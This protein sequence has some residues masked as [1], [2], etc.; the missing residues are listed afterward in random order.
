M[1]IFELLLAILLGATVLSLLAQR[2]HVPYPTL[3]AVGGAALAL[4]PGLPVIAIPP[5]LILALFVAPVLLNAAYESSL[6]D[7]KRNWRPIVSLVLVAVVLTAAVVALVSRAMIPGI[8]W[9]AG[10]ALGA[11]LAPPDAIASL[12][13][14]KQVDPPHRIRTVLE[15]ES[16]LNDASSL[17][18][19]RAAIAAVATGGFSITHDLPLFPV[20]IAASA[21]AGWLAA[22]VVGFLLRHVK[23]VAAL[24]IL[25]F[26]TVF[27]IWL[28]AE[29]LHLSAVVTIVTFGL[30]SARHPSWALRADHRVGTFAVWQALTFVFNVLAFTMIGL[31]LRTLLA[32]IDPSEFNQEILAAAAILAAVILVRLAWVAGTW[33]LQRLPGTPES[34]LNGKEAVVVGWSG[35]RGIVTLAAAMAIPAD[36]PKRDFIQ[37]TAFV[38]VVGT[39]LLQGLTLGLVVKLLKFPRDDLV[40]DE[41]ARARSGALKAA[42]ATLEGERGDAAERLRRDYKDSLSATRAGDDIFATRFSTLRRLS[43]KAGRAELD[44]LRS[45]EI[46]GDDAYRTIEQE[47]DWTDLSAGVD[48]AEIGADAAAS[49]PKQPPDRQAS[50][51]RG[52]I[53][54]V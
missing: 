5:E 30:T 49:A 2:L 38:V 28:L 16:L 41:V 23:E 26:V 7:L 4:L 51:E 32:N 14:L 24:A 1:A 45:E 9:A 33:A 48:A 50:A 25:Q 29:R 42:L 35:M 17:L 44:R 40:A 3:L 6:R 39:L 34:S 18:I 37:L 11:L 46:I 21:L 52:N 53:P 15:G 54:G 31:Q 43:V 13:V 12:A 36:F 10:I 19:Y 27:I 20:V 22:Y 8:P 47:L